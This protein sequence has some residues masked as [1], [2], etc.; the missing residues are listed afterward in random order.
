MSADRSRVA[1]GQVGL[2]PMIF[3]WDAIT[4]E[5]LEMM[6]MPK[7]SRSVSALAMSPDGKY[8]AAADMSDDHKMHLFDLTQKDDAKS[9][10]K[11]GKCIHLRDAKKDRQKIFQ[12]Q[13][14]SNTQFVSVGLEHVCFWTAPNLTGKKARNPSAKPGV[15]L[16]FPSVAVSKTGLCLLA[17][18]DGAIY[19][20]NNGA[21]G[22]VYKGMHQKMV[23]CINIV[24]HPQN[25]NSELVITGGADKQVQ[26]YEL[27]SNKQLTKIQEFQ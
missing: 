9:K 18:S 24:P 4:A 19:T 3:V 7:G 16:G 1:T 21:G 14:T 11:A 22:K 15:K 6:T 17:G 25:Q 5:R 20:Y 26:I 27:G 10:N 12:I 23:S 8:L 13:W 2:E